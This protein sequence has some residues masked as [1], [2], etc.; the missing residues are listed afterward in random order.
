MTTRSAIVKVPP[1]RLSTA[2][3][4]LAFASAMAGCLGP[5]ATQPA[6]ATVPAAS[7]AGSAA[8][9]TAAAPASGPGSATAAPPSAALNFAGGGESAEPG[10]PSAPIASLQ[11]PASTEAAYRDRPDYLSVEAGTYAS[12]NGY[13]ADNFQRIET[14]IHDGKSTFIGRIYRVNRYNL[15]DRGLDGYWYRSLGHGY[16]GYLYA[17]Y[18]PA[19]T[20]LPR[21]A[22]GISLDRQTG[23]IVWSFAFRRMIYTQD[24]VD[25]Y[26]PGISYYFTDNVS[27]A[28][29][30]YDVPTTGGQS[31]AITPQYQDDHHDRY[32]ATVAF[33]Q[34]AEQ[35]TAF[36]DFQKH[37]SYSY[38]VGVER[39]LDPRFSIGADALY[40]H[41]GGLYDRHG[42]DVFAKTWW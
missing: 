26:M 39:R 21:T 27:V 34:M 13:Q 33:G 11:P 10:S 31:L 16:W 14:G 1:M 40:Q 38:T 17:A 22:Y 15:T 19:S 6:P 3:F 25:M 29:R 41:V 32:Y 7:T 20:F 5:G 2:G 36:A 30:W 18:D 35:P 37:S 42:I 24:V 12:N 9:A 23:R 4:V 28:A 8:G